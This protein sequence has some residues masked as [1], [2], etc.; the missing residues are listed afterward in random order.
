MGL[1]PDGLGPPGLLNR[2]ASHLGGGVDIRAQMQSLMDAGLSPREAFTQLSQATGFSSSPGSASSPSFSP[3]SPA[4][5][6]APASVSQPSYAASAGFDHGPPGRVEPSAVGQIFDS[7]PADVQQSIVRG[8]DQLP[9]PVRDAL[10]QLGITQ[11]QVQSQTRSD[12]PPAWSAADNASALHR[13][14]TEQV[15]PGNVREV[16]GSPRAEAAQLASQSQA[17]SLARAQTADAVLMPANAAVVREGSQ[18]SSFAGQ[19]AAFTAQADRASAQM[20]PNNTPLPAGARG[21]EGFVGTAREAGSNVVAMPDR[22]A[23]MQQAMQAPNAPLPSQARPDAVPMQAMA[24]LAGATVLAIPQAAQALPGHTAL[25]APAPPGTDTAAAQARDASQLAP[26]GHTIAGFLRRDLRRGTQPND[27]RTENW[28]L[29]LIAGARKRRANDAEEQM[30]SFQW[31][32]WL[33]TVVAYGAIGV[34]LVLMV[35]GDARLTSPGGAPSLSGYA[36]IVGAVAAL[37]SWHIGKRL[38]PR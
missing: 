21:L 27:R 31:L 8:A 2:L 32:F 29:A 34:A 25:N 11:P 33:L 4:L 1:G 10:D 28:A 24:S 3:G 6:S 14:G 20:L 17:A 12:G 16:F 15:L 5:P 26:A 36:L 18:Q 9:Q 38:S 22:M 23:A 30:T 35:I 13:G 7:L 19:Q 37:A